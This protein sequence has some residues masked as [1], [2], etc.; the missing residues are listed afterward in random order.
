MN[1]LFPVII[2][3]LLSSCSG[4]LRAPVNGPIAIAPSGKGDAA[5]TGT[6]QLTVIDGEDI[7]GFGKIARPVIVGLSAYKA[8]TRHAYVRA[9]AGL[10]VA[11]TTDPLQSPLYST[12]KLNNTSLF[13]RPAIGIYTWAG[14]VT[15]TAE[16]GTPL[17]FGRTRF[18]KFPSS[19]FGG[20]FTRTSYAIN[21]LPQLAITYR[22]IK[23]KG[24]GVEPFLAMAFE[25][26]I[27]Q[28]RTKYDNQ[29]IKDNNKG[30]RFINFLYS[31]DVGARFG[32][33]DVQGYV[34][35]ST[36]GISFKNNLR[37]TRVN[38]YSTTPLSIA[39]GVSFRLGKGKNAGN[40]LS[41]LSSLGAKQ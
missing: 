18:I 40:E 38:E 11:R 34:Q 32:T 25:A 17:T 39:F 31:F 33:Q 28:Y 26:S 30:P 35:L 27:F 9:D 16:L 5:I 1:R 13:L 8:T 36:F 29:L 24:F 19:F 7:S 12:A 3:F 6:S 23:E 10:L 22:G 15:F 37:S 2:L 20:S 4:Y 14:P 21:V 41:S